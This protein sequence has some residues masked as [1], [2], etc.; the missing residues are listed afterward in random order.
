MAT[1]ITVL[2]PAYNEAA[3]IG[4][5]I[6]AV[7]A[8][9]RQADKVIVIPNGCTDDTAA[10]A[11]TYPVTVMELGA[12][13]HRKSEALNRAWNVHGWCSDVVVCHDADTTLPPN[14]LGDWEQEFLTDD[15]FGGSTS[16]FTVQ[17][18]GFLGRL[19]K[20]EYA[21]N[22][23]MGLDR[24]W[25][26]VLAGAGAA[27]SGAVL[28][29]VAMRPDRQGP[30]SY[31][32]AVEDYELTYRIRELGYRTVVSPTVRA[33][34]DGMGS[35]RALWNQRM[36][37]QTGTLQDLL[38]F[39]WTPFTRT[40]WLA[41]LKGLLIPAIRVLWL[42]VMVL[43]ASLGVLSFPW[44]GWLV[45]L[46]YVAINIRSTL[47]IPHRDWKDLLMVVAIF[48]MEFLQCIQGGW[49][50]ASWG[51]IAW[52]KVTNTKRDLWAAQYLAEGV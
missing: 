47:R 48:P 8:Q 32:S 52:Q 41:Q 9:H 6:E 26:N 23:Q 40:D 45:P 42:V 20:A 19:Q 1:T 34:T 4:A 15:L 27:F 39:G 28:R 49:I 31:E 44:W 12:L 33:Y 10:I 30:W 21:S 50:L 38:R 11:R 35:V 14:A 17:Q 46:L 22:I 7:L 5:T 3:S 37:W 25:T 18:A 36:K 51:E 43:A 2:I 24:G 13:A 16:K 29:A